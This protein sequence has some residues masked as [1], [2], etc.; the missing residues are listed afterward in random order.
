MINWNTEFNRIKSE[1]IQ[2]LGNSVLAIEHVGSTSVK[3]LYAKPIIDID[4]ILENDMFEFAKGKLENIGYFYEGDLGI[5]GREAFKYSEKPHLMEH[6]LYVCG[7][8]NSEVKR[9][10]A[11]RDH[12]R[13]HD[14]DRDEY[15][16]IKIEMA[17]KFPHDI[18]NYING[19]Q[20]F[21]LEIYKKCRL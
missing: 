11:F 3:G 4:I 17:K 9:H 14:T 12:L 13:T 18:D 21:I 6:H 20:H 8:D 2:A 19:K 7:K 10:I 5:V 16:E 15:S 1:L